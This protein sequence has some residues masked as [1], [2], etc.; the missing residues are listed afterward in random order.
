MGNDEPEKEREE[1]EDGLEICRML[2][3]RE[4]GKVH[5]LYNGADYALNFSGWNPMT[6]KSRLG[7]VSNNQ[8]RTWYGGWRNADLTDPEIKE[9]VVNKAC[10]PHLTNKLSIPTSSMILLSGIIRKTITSSIDLNIWI[11]ILGYQCTFILQKNKSQD[12]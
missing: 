11:T 12:N 5:V 1:R 10:N 8:K 9:C 4:K 7:S 2:S 6:W 3:D